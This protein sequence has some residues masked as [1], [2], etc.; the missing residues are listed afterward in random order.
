MRET[1]QA[2]KNAQTIQQKTRGSFVIYP[3]LQGPAK[4]RKMA[5]TRRARPQASLSS[6][7]LQAL[8]TADGAMSVIGLC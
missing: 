3:A 4:P 7:P 2:Q 8:G 1:R 6:S 5:I